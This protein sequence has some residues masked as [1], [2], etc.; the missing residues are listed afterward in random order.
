[1]KNDVAKTA[2]KGRSYKQTIN[3][4]RNI[5]G[6]GG[7]GFYAKEILLDVV[8]CIT[9]SGISNFFNDLENWSPVGPGARR[10]MGR[11]LK[12]KI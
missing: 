10:G 4:L 2:L 8:S 3:F 11:I 5:K 6:F 1:M 12:F 9:E 7:T